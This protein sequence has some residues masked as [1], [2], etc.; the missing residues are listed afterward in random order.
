MCVWILSFNAVDPH[1]YP[2]LL[3]M[4]VLLEFFVQVYVLRGALYI[5]VWGSV[6]QI[7]HLSEHFCH[8]LRSSEF[9]HNG[10]SYYYGTQPWGNLPVES[11][12]GNSEWD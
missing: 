4:N 5:D 1:S 10:S 11:L 8:C 7:V 2:S 9:G 12:P 3:E 6:I